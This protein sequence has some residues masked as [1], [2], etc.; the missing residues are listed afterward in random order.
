MIAQTLVDT[1]GGSTDRE[2]FEIV[3]NSKR[4]RT[5]I[6]FQSV[7]QLVG[8][9]RNCGIEAARGK[10]VCCL[11]ANDS[12]APTY[13]EKAVYLLESEGYDVVSTGIQFIGTRDGRSTC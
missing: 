4:P 6:L 8:A 11:D 9:N 7:S 13:L 12:I 10:Y 1:E 2:T 5:R 3:N